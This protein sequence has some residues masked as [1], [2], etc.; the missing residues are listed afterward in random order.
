MP[1]HQVLHSWHVLTLATTVSPAGKQQAAAG[2]DEVA[3]PGGPAA[4]QNGT[5][6][7]T[8]D[9]A[10]H[11]AA[12]AQSAL[13]GVAGVAR[14][15]RTIMTRARAASAGSSRSTPLAALA[16]LPFP[17]HQMPLGAAAGPAA[18]GEYVGW[19]WCLCGASQHVTCAGKCLRG[20]EATIGCHMQSADACG[21]HAVASKSYSRA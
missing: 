9:S 14:S 1:S 16:Q 20:Q 13:A 15:G 8:P 6:G 5:L 18:H 4:A 10:A 17:P 19:A 2:A 21:Q 7:P 12:G 11:A 3:P